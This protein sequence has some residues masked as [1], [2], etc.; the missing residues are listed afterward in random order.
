MNRLAIVILNWNGADMLRRFLPS[1]LRHSGQAQV[2]V[3]DNASTDSSV[4][5][6]RSEFPTVR[7][8]ELDRNYGFAGGY[9]HALSRVEATYYILLNND[10]EVAPHWADTLLQYME[11]HPQVA[12]CQ[13]KLLSYGQRSHFEYAGACGGYVDAWG[14]PYCRGRV[15]SVV[16]QDLGQYNHPAPLLWA[17][18]AA[19]MVRSQVYWQ[20]G[21]LDERFFAHQEEI[22]LCW[23]MRSRGYE[24]MCVPQ[25][26]VWHVGGATLRQD[27][28]QKTYL[29]FR[30]NL[31]LLYKNLPAQRLA[32]VMWMRLWLDA[33]ASLHFLLTGQGRS[34][35]AVW[36]ARRDYHKMRPQFAAAREQNLRLATLSPVPEQ[37]GVSILWQFYARGRNTFQQIHKHIHQ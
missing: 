17:T 13:P 1:V 9:Q 14:Y 21:G 33:L 4:E 2:V 7:C 35:V 23:R 26:V 31:L 6:L 24:L 19:L 12:A 22:D 29:N 32:S 5:V 15:L 36:R 11:A 34:F 8:I 20:V 18:G 25:S 16:E 37:T 3:A 28:P 30:N 27:N 10:V